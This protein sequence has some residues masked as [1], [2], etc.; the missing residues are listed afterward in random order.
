LLDQG[1]AIGFHMR[2]PV[3]IEVRAPNAGLVLPEQ[4]RIPRENA[5]GIHPGW[6]HTPVLSSGVRQ[7]DDIDG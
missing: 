3:D 1:D 2:R 6:H 5:Q 4:Y 7:E